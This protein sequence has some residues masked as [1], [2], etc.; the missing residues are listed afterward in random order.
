MLTIKKI[1]CPTDFSEA[2]LHGL[3]VAVDLAGLFQ[4]ELKVVYVLPVLPPSPT[5][6]NYTYEIPEFE[7][8]LHKDSETKLNEIVKAHVPATIKAESVL[9]HGNAAKEIVRM[10]EEGHIDLIV[11]ATHGH[12][13]WHHLVMG[14]VAEKVLRHAH[15]PVF[16][17]RELRK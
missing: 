16:A 14:S 13:G 7:R 3:D 10:A 17:V 8:I 5:D 9:G 12:S 1:L 6:P 4:A 15:C 2:S 11:I